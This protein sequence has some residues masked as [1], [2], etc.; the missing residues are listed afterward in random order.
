[1]RVTLDALLVLDAIDRAG[2]FAGA[3]ERLF[4]VPSAVSY[5]IHKL[6]QDLGVSIFDRSGHRAKLTK[7]GEQLLKDGRALLRIVEE[8]ERKVRYVDAGWEDRLAI[9]VGDLV[10]RDAVYLL[11]SAFYDT[12]GH[13]STH[14]QVTTEPQA[15]CWETLL[16]GRTDLVIGAAEPG[17][18]VGGY[19]TQALGEV[20]LALV[21]PT[22]HPLAAAQ[23][24]LTSEVVWPY[25]VVR[26][27]AS[28]FD[29]PSAR[30]SDDVV[31]VD[32][33]QSQ[34]DAIRHGLGIGYVPPYLVKKDVDA[35]RLVTKCVADAP[36]LR[37]SVAWR[38][39]EPGH[40]LRWF[41]D[42]L[43]DQDLRARLVPR[44]A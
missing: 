35:G 37:L 28:P 36:T 24:P 13:E 16:T 5:T 3:A 17:P 32:D 8:V 26:Q 30:A 38:S 4:R 15:A 22:G 6:E 34:V 9:A 18:K 43:S 20:Q 1:M 39:A 27:V 33:C 29:T 21:V 2:S 42:Q 14:L 31:T 19:R 44:C 41:V 7:A 40:G 12:P 10:P 11:L 23:E 25:R